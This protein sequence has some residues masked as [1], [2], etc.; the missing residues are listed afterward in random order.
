MKN[1]V[2]RWPGTTSPA[3]GPATV[4]SPSAGA[5]LETLLNCESPLSEAEAQAVLD[6]YLALPDQLP[7]LRFWITTQDSGVDI[8]AGNRSSAQALAEQ[9]TE[10]LRQ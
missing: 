2:T 1:C 8:L 9:V 4:F 6:S 3:S 7:D 5:Q 10:D